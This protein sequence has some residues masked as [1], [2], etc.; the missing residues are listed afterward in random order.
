MEKKVML[1]NGTE[2]DLLSLILKDRNIDHVVIS[3]HDSAMDGLWQAQKGWGYIGRTEHL[4]SP[5]TGPQYLCH[6]IGN[7]QPLLHPQSHA[8]EVCRGLCHNAGGPR[9]T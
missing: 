6:E 7:V 3:F 5:G 4:A 9:H 8:G 1:N 2:A